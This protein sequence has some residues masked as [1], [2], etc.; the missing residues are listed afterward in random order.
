LT[1]WPAVFLFDI[2][3]LGQISSYLGTQFRSRIMPNS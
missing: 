2:K 1:S 3:D